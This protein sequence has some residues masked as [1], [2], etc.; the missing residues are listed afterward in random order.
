MRLPPQREP[1]A[2]RPTSSGHLRRELDFLDVRLSCMTEFELWTRWPQRPECT[3]TARIET[4]LRQHEVESRQGSLHGVQAIPVAAPCTG[5]LVL[6]LPMRLNW[7]S[8]LTGSVV[9]LVTHDDGVKVPWVSPGPLCPPPFKPPIRARP[10]GSPS[11]DKPSS[12]VS[13][14]LPVRAAVVPNRHPGSLGLCAPCLIGRR[15]VGMASLAHPSCHPIPPPAMLNP[16]L[17]CPARPG[18]RTSDRPNKLSQPRSHVS[19]GRVALF[20]TLSVVADTHEP[21]TASQLPV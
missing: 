20:L 11:C 16:M 8:A 1:P 5:H 18:T 12:C 17:D 6:H 4:W 21:D 14:G 10:A 7:R 19:P 3:H 13:Q 2:G 9:L 15:C